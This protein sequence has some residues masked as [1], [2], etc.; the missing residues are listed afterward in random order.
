MD[1]LDLLWEWMKYW[2]EQD[3]MPAKMPDAL[4]VRSAVCLVSS[5]R[6]VQIAGEPAGLDVVGIARQP[7][8][9]IPVEQLRAMIRLLGPQEMTPTAKRQLEAICK[10]HDA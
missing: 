2:D 4:H 1:P 8:G 6:T 5:G 3:H 10:Q 7:T 9:L